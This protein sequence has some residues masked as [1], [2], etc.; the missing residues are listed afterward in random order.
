[1]QFLRLSMKRFGSRS[2][3]FHGRRSLAIQKRGDRRSSSR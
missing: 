1:L 3:R 2:A